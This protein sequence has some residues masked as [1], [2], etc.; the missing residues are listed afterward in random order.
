MKDKNIRAEIFSIVEKILPDKMFDFIWSKYSIWNIKR[1]STGVSV[2]AYYVRNKNGLKKPNYCIFRFGWGRGLFSIA[3]QMLF[4]YEWAIQ[5]NYIPLVDT[6]FYDDFMQEKF[7]LNNLWEHCFQQPESFEGAFHKGN[8]LVSAINGG[9]MLVALH[10]T[11]KA[12]NGDSQDWSAHTQM[13]NYQEYY[14]RLNKLSQKAWL[15][16]P[17]IKEKIESIQ[18]K[19]FHSG[20]CVLGVVLREEFGMNDNEMTEA[21]RDVY[22]KHPKAL[23]LEESY[24]LIVEHMSKWNCTHIFV[25]TEFQEGLEFF[26]EKFGSKVIFIERKRKSLNEFKQINN[27]ISEVLLNNYGEKLEEVVREYEGW[28]KQK[29]EEITISYTVEMATIAKCDYCMGVKC[30]GLIAACILN[31]GKFKD[32]YIFEDSNNIQNY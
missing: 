26:Q 6:E 2:N 15:F 13:Q 3:N 10:S 23:P 11:C 12:I 29:Q 4:F 21:Q 22:K 32:L 28:S 8:V 17:E 24:K 18:K 20:M 16:K 19:L 30:S 25:A 5:N 1:K 27:K 7:G 31:G 14:A 9:D